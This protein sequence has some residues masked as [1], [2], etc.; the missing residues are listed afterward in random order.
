[1]G[2][3]RTALCQGRW[4]ERARSPGRPAV[5][6]VGVGAVSMGAERCAGAGAE[7]WGRGAAHRARR[8][9]PSDAVV[10]EERRPSPTSRRGRATTPLTPAAAH[11]R[12]T[13]PA[14]TGCRP[15]R[16]SGDRRPQ[17]SSRTAAASHDA[18]TGHLGGL[19]HGHE[20]HGDVRPRSTTSRGSVGATP[21]AR[22]SENIASSTVTTR[23]PRRALFGEVVLDNPTSVRDRW[24]C[25]QGAGSARWVPT[26]G[27][28]APTC[29]VRLHPSIS[30][31]AHGATQ[32]SA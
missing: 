2:R 23:R 9:R 19:L 3:E 6:E 30:P 25:S 22:S 12:S 13:R 28:H 24:R 16:S 26:A 17:S 15:S 31:M 11:A 27:E 32:F 4:R 21:N 14:E 20:R 18:G 29:T 10:V 1:M 7:G 5:R 8:A